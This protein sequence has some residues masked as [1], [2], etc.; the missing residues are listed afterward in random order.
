MHVDSQTIIN[1]QSDALSDAL[2]GVVGDIAVAARHVYIYTAV[3]LP[4][5]HT[6]TARTACTPRAA[7]EL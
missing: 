6:M 3:V 4:R 7:H 2:Q 1:A 5:V